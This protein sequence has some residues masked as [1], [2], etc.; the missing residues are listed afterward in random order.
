MTKLLIGL[1]G[2]AGAG[3]STVAKIIARRYNGLVM[4]LAAP[5]KGMI[6]SLGVD[7]KHLYGTPEDKEEP[8]ELFGGKSARFAMQQLGTEFGRTTFGEDF[9]I[10]IWFN[11]VRVLPHSIVIADDVRFENEAKAIKDN[12]GIVIGVVKSYEDF[13]RA[14]V[15]ASE[16]FLKVPKDALV[17]NSGSTA[18]LEAV[19]T[20][21]LDKEPRILFPD[22]ARVSD[23]A[24]PSIPY[25]LSI[26][27]H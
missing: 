14:P 7:P 26:P 16:D 22:E 17:F 8:L 19:V 25:T 13:D 15:H 1:C 5:I 23:K 20:R 12:G 27:K 10:N 6:E 21:I 2:P 11:T 3:K 9:W 18:A 4:P 24:F